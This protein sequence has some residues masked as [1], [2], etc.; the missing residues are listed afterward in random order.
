M[1]KDFEQIPPA[2]L[3]TATAPIA[4]TTHGG[5]AKC[6]QRLERLD[7]PVPRAVALSFDAVHSIAEG[8]MPDLSAVL[9]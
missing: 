6:L 1:Q 7:L 8:Q 4:A 2:S 3:I 5:R 9:S